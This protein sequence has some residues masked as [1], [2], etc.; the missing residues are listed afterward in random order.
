MRVGEIRPSSR[1]GHGWALSPGQFAALPGARRA[2]G[3]AEGRAGSLGHPCP[4]DATSLR[5]HL[6]FGLWVWPS[7]SDLVRLPHCRRDGTVPLPKL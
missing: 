2:V 3:G 4:E 7:W 5:G 6:S 1:E